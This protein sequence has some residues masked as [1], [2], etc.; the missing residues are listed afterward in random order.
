MNKRKIELHGHRGARGLKPE[1]TLPAFEKALQLGIPYLELDLV[2]TKDKEILVHHDTDLNPDLCIHKSGKPIKK[3][4]VSKYTLAEM[5]E[6]DCGSLKNLRFPEQE[7][8][9]NTPP[10]SLKEVITFVKTYETKYPTGE[11]ILLNIELK[12]PKNTK[13]DTL[14]EFAEILLKLLEQ[15]KF[16]GRVVVQSF[17]IDVLPILKAG[18][19]SIRTSALFAPG[20]I[21]FL[22]TE[23]LGI[24]SF[25]NKTLVKSQ[26]VG[27][28]YVSPYYKIINK[29]YIESAHKK[30]LKVLPWTVNTKEDMQKL[31]DTGVDGIISDYPNLLKELFP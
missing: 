15:E 2:L 18:S 14:K 9:E 11:T 23:Y 13:K 21:D 24:D 1:N 20:K 5:K 29:K 26:S 19:R 16:T 17:E 7:I 31:Y 12:F 3:E 30:N 25:R 6:L 10:P 4:P 28:E 22:L 8:V 27:A